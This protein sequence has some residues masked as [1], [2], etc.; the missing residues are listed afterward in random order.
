MGLSTTP[1]IIW[2][3]S[4]SF[5][6]RCPILASWSLVGLQLHCQSEALTNPYSAKPCRSMT[7]NHD[8]WYSISHCLPEQ[9]PVFLQSCPQLL[10]GVS[11]EARLH[12][13]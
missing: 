9:L 1:R 13:C 2:L 11:C 7:W 5:T 3:A 10:D 4:T 6:A 12:F 8:C